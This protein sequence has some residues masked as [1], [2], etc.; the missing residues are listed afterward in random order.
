MRI[1]RAVQER[2]PSS[3]IA[4]I[5]RVLSLKLSVGEED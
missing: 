5:P 3:G 1:W 2:A 4:Q